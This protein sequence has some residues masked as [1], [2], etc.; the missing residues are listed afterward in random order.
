MR[1]LGVI[2]IILG[3]LAIAYKGF[4][5]EKTEQIAKVGPF[6]ATA[7]KQETVPIPAWVGAVGIGVGALLLVAGGRGGKR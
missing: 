3:A 4:T 2:L 6:E 1:M 5:Y 7:K